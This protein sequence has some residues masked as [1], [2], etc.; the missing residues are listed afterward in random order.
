VIDLKEKII[1]LS[2]GEFDFPQHDIVFP[3]TS[4]SITVGEGEVYSGSFALKSQDDEVIQGIIYSSSFRI[5]LGDSGFQGNLITINYNYDGTGLL[6]G[7]VEHGEFTVVTNAG[8]FC[9]YFTAII[10]KPFVMTAYGKVDSL[11]NFRKLSFKDS[12]EAKKLFISNDFYTILK[13]EDPK[14][15]ALY[16]NMRSWELSKES[17]EEFLVACKQKLKISL[18]LDEESRAFLSLDE[19]VKESFVVK[20]NTWGYLPIQI[21][22]IGDFLRID[23]PMITTEDFVGNSYRLEY[24]IEINELHRGS[25]FGEVKI[26]TPYET[27]SYEVVV[28]KDIARDEERRNQD[29]KIA[30]LLKNYFEYEAGIIEHD[31]WLEY[32][33]KVIQELREENNTNEYYL[34]FHANILL[35]GEFFEETRWILDSF[36]YS[37]FSNDKDIEL[38]SYYLYLTAMLSNDTLGQRRVAE[39]LAESYMK[40]PESWKILCMLVQVDSEYKIYSER[41]R[42][43]E[44]LFNL[45]RAS[46]ALFYFEAFKCFREKT[47]SLKKLGT[48]EIRVLYFGAKRRLMTKEL[49]L[50]TANLASQLKSFD[51]ILYKALELSYEAYPE[52]MILSS[53]CNLL[54]R[55]RKAESCH[56]KWFEKAVLAELKIPQLYEYYISSLN[57]GTFNKAFPRTV[58]LYFMH[59]NSLDEGKSAILYSNIIAYE[60][61]SS[62]IY[63][64]YRDEMERF[65]W[66]QLEKRNIDDQLK[67]IY[68]RFI[69]EKAITGERINA[70]YDICH[71]YEVT[72]SVKNM[73]RIFVIGEEGKNT[74]E[75][76]YSKDGAK[77]YLY[78]K[79]D[80]IIWI[81]EKGRY[82][83][84]SVP[85]ESR[86]LFYELRY[87]DM[88]RK[89]FNSTKI[90]RQEGEQVL[91]LDEVRKK[92]PESISDEEVFVLSSKIIRETNYENNNF[93]VY[94]CYNSFRKN[95]YDKVTLSYLVKYYGGSIANMKKLWNTANEY[96][97][98]SHELSERIINQM[99]FTEELFKEE[100]I[101]ISYYNGGAYFRLQQGYLAYIAREFV[102]EDR[103]VS[104]KIFDI[105]CDEYRKGEELLDIIKI[106]V[107]KFYSNRTYDQNIR[108]ILKKF[109]QELSGRQIYFDYFKKYDEE[110]LI[111]VQLWDKTL[112][113]YKGQKGS[114]VVLYYKL[115]REDS[116]LVDYSTE[117]LTPMYEN[118]FVKKIVLFA[119][120]QLEYYFKETVNGA[121][122]RSEKK[123]KGSNG[124]IS[125]S[126]RYGRINQILNADLKRR[127]QAMKSYAL[128][129]EIAMKIFEQY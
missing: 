6:P 71:A 8:E 111:E 67:V 106:A 3:E 83:I 114:R 1:Q 78:T 109:L 38:S 63:A 11:E 62:E 35:L 74:Q 72:T 110:W 60:D 91:T 34:L 29:K 49:A 10:E 4:I 99:L 52:L 18:A 27:L 101:F 86:R 119:N 84:D 53:I 46:S 97:I 117:V 33:L 81:N 94:L 107:L 113:Q 16:D 126:G 20:K 51:N 43:L 47:H 31:N 2:K 22:C 42:V 45:T 124:K 100:D 95:Q 92:G 41:L 85:Y 14:I 96:K 55:G 57:V 75:V 61:D 115:Q 105:I 39:E 73:D 123:V 59:G 26:S 108:V 80:Q 77:V 50:Y 116:E 13:Y 121:T 58:Y 98:P 128:E 88:C 66:N 76:A 15:L 87:L 48:F 44:N 122:Y 56:F 64:H 68:K 102:V 125:E 112:I 32:S 93:L 104:E 37:R 12:E 24:Y 69:T 7:H 36:N 9:I 129:S 89:Y 23:H 82:Y 118:I 90:S 65:A 40:N 25:N 127:S 21:S 103:I 79:Q 19:N 120:E 17:V 54:I 30:S 70:L 28:E 5:R